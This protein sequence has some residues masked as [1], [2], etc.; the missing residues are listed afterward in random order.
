MHGVLRYVLYIMYCCVNICSMIC[1][2]V[3]E[4]RFSLLWKKVVFSDGYLYGGGM[5]GER[6]LDLF[7]D[8]WDVYFFHLLPSLLSYIYIKL[9]VSSPLS[10]SL[11]FLSFFWKFTF[12]YSL[13]PSQIIDAHT[14]MSQSTMYPST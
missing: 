10:F 8:Y 3:R 5:D 2:F 9:T 11:S 4:R 7:F 6:T 1:S 14:N 12:I 13:S